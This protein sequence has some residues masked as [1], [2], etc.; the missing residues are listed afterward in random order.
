MTEKLQQAEEKIDLDNP[1]RC[2]PE[3]PNRIKTVG[4]GFGDVV[5][6]DVLEELKLFPKL[7][8]GEHVKSKLVEYRQVQ[9][10]S[11]IPNENSSLNID[12]E[13]IGITPVHVTMEPKRINVLV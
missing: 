5:I 12:G 8:T 13:L 2:D 6:Q 10:F 9:K 4:F 1:R 7:F 11:I 3:N